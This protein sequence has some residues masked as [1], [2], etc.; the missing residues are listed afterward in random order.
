MTRGAGAG[1]EPSIAAVEY[2]LPERV[3]TNDELAALHPEWKLQHVARRTGVFSRRWCGPDETALDLAEQACAALERRSPGLIGASDA[4]LFCTQTPDHWMPPNACLLQA[5]LG[6]P[7]ST[8]ALDF[9][10]ACSGYVYG[11]YL[12]YALLSSRSARQVL[13]VAAETYSKWMHPDDRGPMTLFGDGASVSVLAAG[14]SAP[15]RFSLGTDGRGA[16]AFCVPA[17]GARTPRSA[18]T[19]VPSLDRSGNVR[20]AEHLMMDGAAV[21]DFVKAE[22]PLAVAEYLRSMESSIADVDLVILHQASQ[23]ALD[24]LHQALQVPES[25]RFTN[26]GAIGNTVS[27]SL[28]I[29]LRDAELAGALRPGM[30]VLLVGFGVG[31]SWGIT[32]ITWHPLQ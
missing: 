16:T 21:L 30:R 19:S 22:V 10:L 14:G 13:L 25:K 23:V 5:R 7:R 6:L 24:Y 3:V 31:L 12:G 29:A 1:T 20:T 8:A 17:G 4:I 32:L 9:S 26:L 18:S 15:T 28:P 2:A 11:L 27:A